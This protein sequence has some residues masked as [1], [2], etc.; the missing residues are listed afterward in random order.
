MEVDNSRLSR[1]HPAQNNEAGSGQHTD[2]FQH[3]QFQKHC[4]RGMETR[5]GAGSV[6]AHSRQSY[7]PRSEA[8]PVP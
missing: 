5:S 6:L 4:P 1:N 3:R 8:Y 7:K 2:C